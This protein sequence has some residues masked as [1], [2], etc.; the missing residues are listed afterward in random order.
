MKSKFLGNL[1]SSEYS[2]LTDRLLDIQ[3]NVCFICQEKIDLNLHKTNIDHITPLVK[4]GKDN[5]DNFAVTHESCNKSK[6]DADLKMARKLF[7]LRKV[8]VHTFESQKRVA[9][10]KDVLAYYGGSKHDFKYTLEDD[11]LWYSFSDLGDNKV[12][13]TPVFTDRLSGEK[14]CFIDFPLEYLYHD[15]LINP[16]GINSSVEKLIKEFDKG[17]PQLHSSIGRMDDDKVKIFDGQHKAVSQIVLGSKQLL[18]RLF[19]NPDVDRLIE[20]NTNAGS[21]LRQIVFDKSVMRQLNNTLYLERIRKY[22]EDHG[23]NDDDYSF[24]EQQLAD[25]F[26]GDKSIKKYIVDSIK[27]S[28]TDS[29]E[30]KLKDYTDKGGKAKE[31]P[32]SYSAYDKTFL[33]F[34]IDGKKILPT[35]IGYKSETQG[36]PRELEIAQTIALLNIIAQEIYIDKFDPEI[37]VSKIES[38]LLS[39][40]DHDISDDHLVAYRMSKEEVMTNWL[41]YVK[42]VIINYF[43]NTGTMVD[44]T[45]LMQLPFD[46]Q[47]WKN[48]RNFI[49]NLKSLP[50][51]RNRTLASSVFSGK[52]NY[53]YWK[54]IFETGTSP[55][56]FQ[57]LVR[58]L[59]FIEMIKPTTST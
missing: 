43:S 57:V 53:D 1:S 54:T 59:N 28:I 12:Y 35:P 36:N 3:N 2:N 50:V 31:M 15:E 37:G 23:L 22:Q 24:S 48:I 32:I 10:L 29:P 18:I 8:L 42:H 25:Y 40:K 17:N 6:Q 39:G 33:T 51:W 13:Q 46:E 56:G 21:T 49:I 5:E 27:F 47:L 11:K 38:K 26:K 45:S 7:E 9:S 19:L 30:N 14:T 44:G 16:R 41:L 20:T 58:P 4:K 52:N 55:D 34:F